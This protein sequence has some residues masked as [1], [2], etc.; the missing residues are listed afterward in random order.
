MGKLHF[1]TKRFGLIPGR[2]QPAMMFEAGFVHD[3]PD[4][5]AEHWYFKRHCD[6]SKVGLVTKARGEKAQQKIVEALKHAA[7]PPAPEPVKHVPIGQ[8]M[9]DRAGMQPPPSRENAVH[10]V[11][12]SPVKSPTPVHPNKPAVKR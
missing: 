10:D 12:T 5:I 6:D 3:V 9:A 7:E 11:H 8:M 4:E 2:G 1:L